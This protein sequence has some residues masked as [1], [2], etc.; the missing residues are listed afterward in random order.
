MHLGHWSP[1]TLKNLE[2]P[3]FEGH[4]VPIQRSPLKARS[5]FFHIQSNQKI[6]K[7][8]RNLSECF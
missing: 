5:E 7:K 6:A 3:V 1:K 8:L 2:K 4:M